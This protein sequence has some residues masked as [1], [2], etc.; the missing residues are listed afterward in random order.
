MN[1]AVTG[2]QGQLGLSFRKIS[3]SYSQHRLF[4]AGR[5]EADITRRE[6]VEHFLDRSRAEVL[7]NCAAY[8]AVDRAEKEQSAAWLINAEG[9]AL[10]S[11]IAKERGIPLIHFSTDYVFP[12]TGHQPLRENDPT[13]PQN[14]YGRTKL[15]GEAAIKES[16]C[17]GAIF[18]TAWLYS[19]F[20][21]NFVRTMIR[22]GQQGISPRVVADQI[23][24]PTYAVDLADAVM[25]IVAQPL[26]CM[27]IY[28]YSN[29]GCVSWFDFAHEIFSIAGFPGRVQ[30]ISSAE[31][32]TDAARPAYSVL[33]S[34]KIAHKGIPILFWKNS[35]RR[36]YTEIESLSTV[37]FR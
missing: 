9:P 30:A 13:S 15:A 1:I 16:G 33:S 12:G 20:G 36:C 7:I 24:S 2:S 23:G 6:S 5:T 35:L 29:E 14:T 17:W 31:Y 27:E 19:E 37:S 25:K 4:F 10:L 28:H 11:H 22:L 34:Q 18:R 3:A 8:T 21:H 26:D 32:P